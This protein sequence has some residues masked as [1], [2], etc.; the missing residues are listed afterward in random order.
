MRDKENK[1]VKV[2]VSSTQEEKV[3]MSVWKSFARQWKRNPWAVAIIGLVV[4]G[5][6]AVGT[7]SATTRRAATPEQASPAQVAQA[8]YDWYLGYAGGGTDGERANPLADRVYRSSQHLTPEFIA[9]V[10]GTL[11]SPDRGGADP[12][13]CAQDLP[14][15]LM[16]GT[17]DA[18]GTRATVQMDALYTGSPVAYHLNVN[19]TRTSD[20]WKIDGVRC[21]DA[22]PTL[23][24]AEQTVR[25]FYA[26]YLDTCSRQNPLSTG[27]Y[28]DMPFLSEGLVS[29]IDG[30]I[31]GFERGGYD[32]FLCA[33]DI[34]TDFSITSMTVGEGEANAVVTT[35]FEGHSFEVRLIEAAGGWLIDDVVC[36]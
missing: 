21:G 17:V 19:L 8:F 28:R 4:V 23:L 11:E 20:G 27:S 30:I 36:Q 12:F 2:T 29:K 9:T 33:Q 15:S 7:V 22:A 6:L 26:M 5:A 16:A 31:N 13:L 14:M 35:S 34:P 18:D 24:T 1:L 32:P 3:D 10:D 25:S